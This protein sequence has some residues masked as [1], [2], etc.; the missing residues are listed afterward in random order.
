MLKI[1]VPASE[2]WDEKLQEFVSTKETV[3]ELE[4]SLLSLSKWESKW[5]MPFLDDEPKTDEQTID[6]IRCMTINKVDPNVYYLLSPQN[7]E[8]IKEYINAK[9]TATFFN[10]E[11][12]SQSREIIT[13][14]LVYYWMIQCGIPFECQK[15]HLNRL[16]TLI[17]VCSIKQAPQKKMSKNDIFRRNAELNAQRRAKLNTKG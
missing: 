8:T 16:I 14:E 17:R 10:D 1:V 11:N 3:L 6:Y 5:C 7:I 13:N 4:H 9:M 12:G 15:W 2:G